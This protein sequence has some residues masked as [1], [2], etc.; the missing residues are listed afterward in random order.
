MSYM[1]GLASITVSVF[2]VLAFQGVENERWL[3][4]LLILHSV[5]IWIASHFED[6]LENRIKSLENKLKD[7]EKGGEG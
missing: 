4:F 2:C 6:K 3:P 1:L 5:F 7:G